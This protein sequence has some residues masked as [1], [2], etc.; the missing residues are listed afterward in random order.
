MHEF[1]SGKAISSISGANQSCLV[2]SFDV[3]ITL[4]QFL[5]ELLMDHKNSSHLISWTSK[6][7]MENFS[8]SIL[9]VE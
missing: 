5:L 6:G 4:W 1:L 3:N 9:T 2:G 7:K 8:I